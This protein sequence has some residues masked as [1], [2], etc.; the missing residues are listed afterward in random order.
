MKVQGHVEIQTDGGTVV[1]G[2]AKTKKTLDALRDSC[3]IQGG[4]LDI[5]ISNRL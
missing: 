1:I 2:S 4:G 5:I 3:I